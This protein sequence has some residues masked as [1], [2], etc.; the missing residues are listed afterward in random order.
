MNINIPKCQNIFSFAICVVVAIFPLFINAQ[1]ASD[2]TQRKNIVK[3]DLTSN[4]WYK[5]AYNLTYER[6]V[7]KNRTFSVTFGSQE[8]VGIS[9]RI[10]PEEMEI[11]KEAGTGFKLAGDYRFYLQKENRYN[12]PHGVFIGPYIAYHSFKNKWDISIDGS[13]GPQTGHV[14]GRFEILNVGFQAG[15][16]FLLGNRWAIDMSFIGAS[17]SYYRARMNTTGNF[18]I[19]D[20]EINQDILDALIERFPVLGD[21]MDDQSLDRSGKLDN[22]G[23]GIRYQIHVGYAFGG[24]KKKK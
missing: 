23:M 22:W 17:L 4:V 6:V 24:G 21:L 14:D 1:S 18:D 7:K 19:D 11:D 10:R 15:Y 13:S 9:A 20:S 16:Q 2:S 8:L 3:L 5:S 12:G